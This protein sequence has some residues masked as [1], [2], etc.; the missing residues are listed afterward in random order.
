ML[1]KQARGTFRK[2]VTKP[3]EQVAAPPVCPP[4]QKVPLIIDT[5]AS[6]DVDD[7]LAICMAHA[8]ERRGEAH[9]L[10]IMHDAG[11]PEGQRLKD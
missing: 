3:S 1:P 11:I 7:V 4:S 5:D 6:F 8:L 9:I 2:N 10:A